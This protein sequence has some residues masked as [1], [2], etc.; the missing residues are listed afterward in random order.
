MFDSF[1][2]FSEEMSGKEFLCG[3]IFFVCIREFECGD[4]WGDFMK[5]AEKI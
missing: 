3:H 4:F 2:E 5:F 1:G